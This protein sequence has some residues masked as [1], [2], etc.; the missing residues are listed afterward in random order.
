MRG[1]SWVHVK[2]INYYEQLISCTWLYLPQAAIT[3]DDF[4]MFDMGEL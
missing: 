4:D 3:E 1:S 2:Y